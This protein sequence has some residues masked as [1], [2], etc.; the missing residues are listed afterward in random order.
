MKF[1][2][3]LIILLKKSSLC[4]K[5]DKTHSLKYQQS[6]RKIIYISSFLQLRRPVLNNQLE[7][8]SLSLFC[9]VLPN[10]YFVHFGS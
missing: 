3:A 6:F 9:H 5:G 8:G 7:H 4:N 1:S 2:Q 10:S